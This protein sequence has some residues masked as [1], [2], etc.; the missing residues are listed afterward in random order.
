MRIRALLAALLSFLFLANW[1]CAQ[2]TNAADGCGQAVPH[3]IKFNGTLQDAE[4]HPATGAVG[5]TFSVYRESTGGA[6]LWQETQNVSADQQ[7]DFEVVLGVT[8]NEGVPLDIFTG[9][10][11][12]WLGIQPII[13]GQVEQPRVLLVSVPYA[14]KAA[15]AETL[16]GLPASAFLQALTN[17]SV[18]PG[19]QCSNVAKFERRRNQRK[20]FAKL[21]S[22]TCHNIGRQCERSPAVFHKHGHRKFSNKRLQ[23]DRDY[24]EPGEHAVCRSVSWGCA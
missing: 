10:E 14:L 18:R 20:S 4:G 2:C 5:V 7:G 16:G 22:P 11:P 12:R 24:A 19:D 9:A 1:T 21:Y 15:D 6:P 13:P 23:R 8:K 17:C 3:L